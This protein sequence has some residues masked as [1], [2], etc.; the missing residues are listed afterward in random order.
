MHEN[1]ICSLCCVGIFSFSSE[2]NEL[3]VRFQQFD[4]GAVWLL[5]NKRK[6][7]VLSDFMHV[8]KVVSPLAFFLVFLGGKME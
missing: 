8:I 1:S 4:S 6:K 3:H 2:L 5:E 7:N